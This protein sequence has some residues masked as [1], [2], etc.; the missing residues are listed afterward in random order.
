[1]L[2]KNG[3]IF[4]PNG[5]FLENYDIRCERGQI[6]M[7]NK[8][9]KPSKDEKIIDLRGYNLFPGFID[10]HS[11]VGLYSDPGVSAN[12]DGNE[13]GEPVSAEIR[14]IDAINLEDLAFKDAV[15]CGITSVF[16]GPGSAN[17]IGGQSAFIKTAG[18]NIVDK[19]IVKSYC[20]L[21]AALGENPKNVY[22]ELKK[23]P[24][25]RMG[26]AAVMRK[27]FVKAIN[28]M[29]KQRRGEDI[30]QDLGLDAIVDVL[31][32]KVPLRCHAHRVDDIATI[33]RIRDEF[34]F[35]LVI[36]HATDGHKIADYI[37]EKKVPCVVGPS[38]TTRCKEEL[39]DKTFK[40]P[41]VLYS[42][43]VLFAI[44]TD[45]PVIPL[46]YLPIMAG[47]AVKEGLPWIEAIKGITINAAEICGV[48]SRLG[49]IDIGK[50][51][52]IT[53]YKG[54][55]LSIEGTCMLTLVDGNIGY[56]IL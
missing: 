49:S 53:V 9:I 38:M 10:A 32:R 24:V 42:K 37:S 41:E 30:D 18:S 8:N 7:I 55:P 56:N 35:D 45:A 3:K 12:D 6:K 25:T 14:A 36:E 48:S 20:G 50:D 31:K 54:D 44:T 17:I 4:K 27:T 23:R 22:G 40:T 33:I 26:N 1:M 51:A 11:H 43:G 28:Y 19:R 46:Q 15:N 34:G 52:D 29:K 16:T 39:K 21:K 47:F 2:L 5:T 13:I